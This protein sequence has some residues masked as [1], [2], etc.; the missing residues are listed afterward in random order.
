MS[1]APGK[2]PRNDRLAL[3]LLEMFTRLER[4]HLLHQGMALSP[5]ERFKSVMA[6]LQS[7]DND[8]ATYIYERF[9][10]RL[11]LMVQKQLQPEIRCKVDPE[12]IL[13]EA[14]R[15]FFRRQAAGE[16]DNLASWDELWKLLVVITQHEC[17]NRINHFR[18]ARRD[19]GR[20]VGI[21][22]LSRQ[23]D[24]EGEAILS[25]PNPTP[26]EVAMH[27][28]TVDRLL[29]RLSDRDRAILSL[30]LH[31]FSVKEISD[32]IGCTQRTVYRVLKRVQKYLQRGFRED[33]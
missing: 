24:P 19:V 5:N 12:D 4:F 30:R 9:Y 27:S 2:Q 29:Q 20:E 3:A 14:L 10:N 33:G 28:E 31:R 8:A 15:S 21:Q 17:L 25:D 23:P 18:L 32:Q 26:E 13:Q 22:E 1:A 6:R 16:Y 7:G 11:I